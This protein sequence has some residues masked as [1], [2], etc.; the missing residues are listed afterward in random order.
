MLSSVVISIHGVCGA[1]GEAETRDEE[2]Y[3]VQVVM[4]VSGWKHVFSPRRKPDDKERTLYQSEKYPPVRSF[5][6]KAT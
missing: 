3:F 2:E 5:L 1:V 4:Q 6:R